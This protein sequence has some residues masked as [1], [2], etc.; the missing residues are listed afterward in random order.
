MSVGSGGSTSLFRGRRIVRDLGRSFIGLGPQV[1]VGGPVVFAM[2]ITA[3]IVFFIA[4]CSVMGT[5]RKSFNCGV[6]IFIVLFMA[7]LFTGFTRTVTRTHNGTRT[8]DLHGAHRR[9]PTGGMRNGGVVA[10]D[11]SRLGGKSMFIYRTKSIVPSSNRVVRKL[12]SVSRDTVANRSTPMVHR[13]NKSGD[14][15]AKKAG[16]LSSHVGMVI[17]ARPKRDFLSGVVTLM[18]NTSHRGAPGRVT[19]AVLLT[20]FAL[21]FIVIYIALGPFTSCDGAIVAVTSLVSLFIYLVPAAVNKLLSTVNVTNV[22][23][24]LHTG[25]V[26]GSKGTMRATNSVSALLLSGANAVAVN[27]HGTARFRATPNISL[28][29][30]MRGYLLSSLSSRAP[31]KGSV[32]RLKHRSNVHVHGL[33][34]TKTHVVGFATRAGYSNISLTS[35]ARV[36]GKTFSTVHG[37]M[38]DTKGGFPGR[39]RRVVSAVSDGNNAPLIMYIGQGMMN[40][41]RLRSVV[42][43][44]VRRHFRHLHG[45]NIGAIVIANSGPLATGCVTRGTKMSSFVTRTEPRSGVRCVGGR[46]R[47]KGLITVVKSKAGSTPTLTR[48]GMKMT[49][50]DNARTTGRTNGVISLSGSPAGLVR[51][52]RVNG[53][54]LVAHNAL[55]AFSVTGSITGCF[56]VIPTLFVMTVPRLTTL[57]VVGLRD[58]RDTVLSTMVFG[59]VV[60]PVLVPLTLHNMRCGPVNTDTLLHH[61]LLVCNINN[62]V[63]PFIN[64]GLVS[65]LMNLFFW[66]GGGDG[67]GFVRIFGGGAYFLYLFLHILCP[68]LI[69]IYANYESWRKGYQDDRAGQGDDKDNRYQSS[70]CGKCLLLK[71]PFLYKQQV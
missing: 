49:V 25:I 1:V 62:I 50:G 14:S 55:A 16:M 46:R 8:S 54:L 30:F 3:T 65:L 68:C 6:T 59:T 11:S 17:A 57:G 5:S 12:T 27:G 9:A 28:R 53:R 34:A 67:R 51:V 58:P 69:T 47:T 37:V 2:R 42:G 35:K 32:I 52:I 70:I 18:R 43:P 15:I 66:L 64:V 71:A 48:T 22:S 31:R 19:L 61:G 39:I 63:I 7:L 36:H 33:G 21:I 56:T 13:T 29:H 38:R 4:L 26:A 10:M 24:T 60:V 44:N 23:H 20:N 41:V 40:I 45:V